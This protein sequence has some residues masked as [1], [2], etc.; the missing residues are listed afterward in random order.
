MTIFCFVTKAHV[1]A[2]LWLIA[3]DFQ[4]ENAKNLLYRNQ[5][6]NSF[7]ARSPRLS[8]SDFRERCREGEVASHVSATTQAIQVT[9]ASVGPL[10]DTS[11]QQVAFGFYGQKH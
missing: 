9:E 7:N 2:R 10:S 1:T 6:L 5:I 11:Q 8:Q 3:G 4:I